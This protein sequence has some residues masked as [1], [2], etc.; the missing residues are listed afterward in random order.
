M[1][2]ERG[3]RVTFKWR[4]QRCLVVYYVDEFKEDSCSR[5]KEMKV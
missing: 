3:R 4:L 1:L 2:V 5:E